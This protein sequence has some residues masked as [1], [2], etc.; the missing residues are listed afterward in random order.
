MG[1]VDCFNVEIETWDN[2]LNQ[3][4]KQ[5]QTDL[6]DSEKKALRDVQRM[7]IKFRDLSCEFAYNSAGGG[8]IRNPLAADCIL[9]KTAEQALWIMQWADREN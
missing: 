9:Q 1:M 8:S 7:W 6:P 4:Y 3:Y 2:L 5:A